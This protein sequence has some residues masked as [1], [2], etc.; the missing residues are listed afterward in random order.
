VS[1]DGN[2]GTVLG[3]D[4]PKP[5][6]NKKTL[7][8]QT[9][10]TDSNAYA[11][12]VSGGGNGSVGRDDDNGSV[13]GSGVD[14]GSISGGGNGSIDGIVGNGSIDRGGDNGSVVGRAADKGSISGGGGDGYT[15]GFGSIV[16][17]VV[18]TDMLVV[19]DI[20]GVVV[21]VVFDRIFIYLDLSNLCALFVC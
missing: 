6:V 11:A 1:V 19:S 7:I 18:V 13:V 20:L 8:M 14:N 2:F 16:V 10:E 21:V 17:M 9:D 15:G 12:D 4:T 5:K 3:K